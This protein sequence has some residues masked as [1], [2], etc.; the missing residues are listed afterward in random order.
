M[1]HM[2][3]VVANDSVS[4][5]PTESVKSSKAATFQERSAHEIR[6]SLTGL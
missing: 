2:C 6:I 5:L 1:K 3:E 4:C